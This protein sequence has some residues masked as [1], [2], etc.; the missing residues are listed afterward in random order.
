MAVINKDIAYMALPLSI[1]RGNPFPVDE[2]SVWYD[3]G[4][5]TT[6]ATSSPVAYVGQIVTLVNE[7]ESTVEA[8][9]IQNAAGTLVKLAATTASGDLTED[10]LELQG[11]VSN[12]EAS[13]GTKGDD[14]G[15]AANNL[16][17][18][19]KEV[20]DAYEAADTAT[21]EKFAQYYNKTETD[22]KIDEKIATAISTTYKAAGSVAF[23]AL[24]ELAAGEEGK[25]YNISNE[26]T[27]NENFVEGV[28]Q[29]YP[30]GTNVVCIDIDDAGTYKW[31]VLSGF[32][33]LSAYETT[34]SVD[35]KLNKK[36]DKVEGSSLV[37]DTLIAKLTGMAE[38]KSVKE[39]ELVVDPESKE[40]SVVT[41]AQDKV[42]GLTDALGNKVNVEVGKSLVEDTLIAKLTGMAEIKG[43]SSEFEIGSEDKVLSIKAIDQS[44]ITGL[45]DALAG[46]IHEVKVNEIPLLASDGSVNIGL[47][48]SSAAGVVMGSE[49]ENKVKVDTDG[50]ME[51]NSLN[52]NKLTQ[53]EGEFLVL[54]GGDANV[55]VIE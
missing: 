15:I 33:D 39:G 42:T 46:K 40:L 30:A 51:V 3:M 47:A 4:E 27:T 26:F 1:R 48:T 5:L 55:I 21:N 10:V 36:V 14:S 35:E 2:Y 25:V 22:G 28:G 29:K 50:T 41:I 49:A 44:K 13:V 20:K 18:A 17:A 24:P 6:Y 43:V 37:Q 19:I 52:I 32:V 11:K 16:W 54:D 45:S 7:S 34:A 53:A 38:I 8:Y 12:L 31:D 9:M 23:E